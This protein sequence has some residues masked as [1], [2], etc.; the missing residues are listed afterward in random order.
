[1]LERETIL[2]EIFHAGLSYICA[3]RGLLR[4][5]SAV[6]HTL[7]SNFDLPNSLNGDITFE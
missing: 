1:M 5:C 6:P 3:W 4:L 7:S 2:Y